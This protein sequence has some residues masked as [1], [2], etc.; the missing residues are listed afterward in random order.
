MN[1]PSKRHAD[2]SKQQKTPPATSG[3][4]DCT[5]SI[6][7]ACE[8]TWTCDT[9]N[10]RHSIGRSRAS[11]CDLVPGDLGQ[12]DT[13]DCVTKT[14][15]PLLR[16]GDPRW[17]CIWFCACSVSP[18]ATL[19]WCLPTHACRCLRPYHNH[20]RHRKEQQ[21]ALPAHCFRRSS[22]RGT[23]PPSPLGRIPGASNV[24]FACKPIVPLILLW[25]LVRRV[26]MR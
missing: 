14:V 15:L 18:I 13:K 19:R 25:I 10:H 9:D 1:P 5:H 12:H 4:A 11:G 23:L 16:N 26:L 17:S 20:P 22:T 8:H 21:L 6:G 2:V 7:F 24:T 3:N